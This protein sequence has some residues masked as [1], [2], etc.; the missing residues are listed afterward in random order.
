MQIV[1]LKE[2]EGGK[3]RFSNQVYLESS[4]KIMQLFSFDETTIIL[5]K[6]IRKLGF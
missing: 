5:N 6:S 3:I 2:K 1:Y 4:G